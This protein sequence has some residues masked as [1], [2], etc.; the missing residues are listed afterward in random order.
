LTLD[1]SSQLIVNF[2]STSCCVGIYWKGINDN[3]R[4]PW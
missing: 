3:S 2:Q 1:F 4:E